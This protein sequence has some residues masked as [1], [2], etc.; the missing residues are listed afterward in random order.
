[1]KILDDVLH[2]VDPGNCIS[3][4]QAYHVLGKSPKQIIKAIQSGNIQ[5]VKM[6]GKW[7]IIQRNL[8]I[9]YKIASAQQTGWY[10]LMFP[11]GED[12]E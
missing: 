9:C 11:I 3:P 4:K 7:R 8:V 5:A 10:K 2:D 6:H 12:V 1:M